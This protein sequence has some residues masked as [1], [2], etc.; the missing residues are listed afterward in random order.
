MEKTKYCA[1]GN[2][3]IRLLSYDN[4]WDCWEPCITLTVNLGKKL[5]KNM[6]YVDRNNVPNA[7]EFIH[8]YKLGEP[9]GDF[10]FSGFCCYPLYKFY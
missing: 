3:A 7:E 6:A 1:N 8:K 4:E 10:G 5:P 9:T 2:L